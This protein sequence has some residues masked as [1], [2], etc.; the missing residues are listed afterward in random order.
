VWLMLYLVVHIAAITMLKA[1]RCGAAEESKCAAKP[2]VKFVERSFKAQ[3]PF[4]M[5][6]FHDDIFPPA[7][8]MSANPGFPQHPHRG[9]ETVTVMVTGLTD[10]SD[11]LGGSGRYGDGDVQW[12]T[13]GRGMAH[14]ECPVFRNRDTPNIGTL[15]Q[16]WLNLPR[17]RKLC[18]PDAKMLWNEDIPV[19]DMD[20]VSVRVIAGEGA[21][22]P[23]PNSWAADPSNAVQILHATLQPGAVWTISRRSSQS[24]LTIYPFKSEDAAAKLEVPDGESKKRLVPTGSSVAIEGGLTVPVVCVGSEPLQV[25]VLEGS[26]IAEPVAWHGPFVMSNA[27]EVQEAFSEYQKG[28]FGRWPWKAEAPLHGDAPRFVA[29]A[30]GEREERGPLHKI[31]VPG[32]VRYMPDMVNELFG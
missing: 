6:G 11:S 3:D 4:L 26:A 20:G 17:S 14:S 29:T 25:L 8:K 30:A 2:T 19:L 32:P 24:N 12:M 16:L 22:S 1:F 5:C 31:I 13:A 18:E 23:P 27:R 21:L 28:T 7:S 15:F 9:M 10:H